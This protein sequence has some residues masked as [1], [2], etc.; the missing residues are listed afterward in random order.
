MCNLLG[1]VRWV[2][3]M[4][5]SYRSKRRKIQEQLKFLS[6]RTTVLNLVSSCNNANDLITVT[7]KTSI[8]NSPNIL[9]TSTDLDFSESIEYYSSNIQN[10]QTI[11]Q[12]NI[13]VED[14]IIKQFVEPHKGSNNL[15]SNIHTDNSEN[16]KLNLANWVIKRNVP[17]NT[18]NDLLSILKKHKCFTDIPHN[19]RTLLGSNSSKVNEIRTVGPGR[20]FHFGLKIGIE[21]CLK[22]V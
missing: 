18:V 6:E 8:K 13:W 7:D 20:Y 5:R 14:T 16:F 3:K 22:R 11:Q 1:N 4:I 12:N 2:I 9:A 15:G 17:Q 21:N 10:V 19:C